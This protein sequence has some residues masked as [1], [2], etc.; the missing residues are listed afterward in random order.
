M[1]FGNKHHASFPPRRRRSQLPI[2]GHVPL[3]HAHDTRVTG[4]D[5]WLVQVQVE[6]G[7]ADVVVPVHATTGSGERIHGVGRSGPSE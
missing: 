4:R 5:I 6:T 2:A 3:G 1:S 7:D